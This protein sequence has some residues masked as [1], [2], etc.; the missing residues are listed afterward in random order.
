MNSNE[1]G[2]NESLS[3]SDETLVIGPPAASQEKLKADQF[4]A[5]GRY[6]VLS[7]VGQGAM[8][9]VYKVEQVALRKQFALKLLSPYNEDDPRI[10]RFQKE[11]Q[12]ASQL[13]H[14]NLVRAIDFGMAEGNRPFLVMDFVAGKTLA[15]FLEERGRLTLKETID[16]FTPICAALSYAHAQGVIHRDIKPSNIMLVPVQGEPGRFTPKVVDFGIAKIESTEESALT[17]TGE[18]FGTPL[19][20]S[21]EQCS[22]KSVDKRTDIYALGCVIY[23]AL[24]GTPPF[25]G[26]TAIAIIAQHLNELPQSMSQASMGTTFPDALEAVI[27]KAL[28]KNPEARQAD[29]MKL[30]QELIESPN[31]IVSKPAATTAVM[32]AKMNNSFRWIIAVGAMAILGVIAYGTLEFTHSKQEPTGVETKPANADDNETM[33]QMPKSVEPEHTLA[34][35]SERLSQIVEG[36]RVFVFPPNANLGDLYWWID[37][38]L[39]S[40]PATKTAHTPA[41]AKILLDA[42]GQIY[43]MTPSLITRFRSSDLDGV[44]ISASYSDHGIQALAYDDDMHEAAMKNLTLLGDLRILF[45]HRFQIPPKLVSTPGEMTNLRWLVYDECCPDTSQISKCSNLDN[46]RVLFVSR[47]AHPKKLIEKLSPNIRALGLPR[48]EMDEQDLLAINRLKSLNT[49]CLTHK[50][51]TPELITKLEKTLPRLKRLC[52]GVN[53]IGESGNPSWFRFLANLDKLAIVGRQNGSE[54]WRRIIQKQLPHCHVSFN[55]EFSDEELNWYDPRAFNP[56]GPEY[57]LSL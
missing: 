43:E 44:R 2:E 20:M 7:Y 40:V 56:D 1:A 16:L 27:A 4:L 10:R 41:K 47:Y 52:I 33:M 45:F 31:K 26:D 13:E 34:L 46:L 14:P 18:I 29:C 35:P 3:E 50:A 22:G 48:C 38:Q 5:D 32:E 12:A 11:A 53:A 8:A 9:T 23:Q 49:L 30:A 17:R 25:V 37:G 36:E 39:H 24:A 21:P 51:L 6:K 42:T 15:Q 57:G 55:E 19:Y 54:Q 28:S